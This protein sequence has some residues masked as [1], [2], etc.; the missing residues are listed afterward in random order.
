[1]SVLAGSVVQFYY[2]IKDKHGT[3]IDP[4]SLNVKIRNPSLVDTTYTYGVH[5]QVV[6]ESTGIYYINIDTTGTTGTWRAKWTSTGTGQGVAETSLI[7][8]AT[9]I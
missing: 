5:A 2:K 3:L 7:V 9:Q 8:D 6:R 1:M 4:S